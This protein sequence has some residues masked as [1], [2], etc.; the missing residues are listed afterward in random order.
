MPVQLPVLRQEA[1][2]LLRASLPSTIEIQQTLSKDVGPVLADPTATPPGAL[3]PLRQCCARHAG[4]GRTPGGTPGG[5][6][7]G[8]AGDSAASRVAAWALYLRHC[9]RYRLWDGTRSHGAHFEPFFTTKAPGEGTGMGLALVHGIVTNHGGTV[10]VSSVVGQG[11]TFTVYLPCSIDL[12]QDQT[13]QESSLHND[14]ST[15]AERVLLV[16]DEAARARLGEA[17]LRRLDYEVV[18]G[19]SSTEALNVFNATCTTVLRFGDYRSDDAPH[20]GGKA[21]SGLA[22]SAARYSD[23]PLHWLQS[24]H[25]CGA[26]PGTWH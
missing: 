23:H 6:G 2:G 10:L 14:A 4:D 15:G 25:A 11:T 22:A 1:L 21:C 18:V 16:D 19:T 24:C 9:G 3:E 26:S 5:C 17:I 20:D 8:R 7:S 12:G 13:S